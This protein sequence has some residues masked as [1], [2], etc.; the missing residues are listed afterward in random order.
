MHQGG[1]NASA[2]GGRAGAL[3]GLV[4]AVDGQFELLEAHGL[5]GG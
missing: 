2:R 3:R 4:L 5:L 1:G